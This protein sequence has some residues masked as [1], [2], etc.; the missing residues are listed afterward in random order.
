MEDRLIQVLPSYET[1]RLGIHCLHLF[2]ILLEVILP[3]QIFLL[4]PEWLPAV[5]LI[6]NS[7]YIFLS[8]YLGLFSF[9]ITLSERLC[10]CLFVL[11]LACKYFVC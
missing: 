4:F 1:V 5:V 11:L 10:N 2:L 6:Q 8:S 9:I 3:V 7:S